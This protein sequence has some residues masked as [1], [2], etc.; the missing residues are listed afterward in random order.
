MNH[1]R[2]WL[3]VAL[4]L[5][6]C[7]LPAV[8][9]TP[10][11]ADLAGLEALLAPA[12]ACPAAT[13]PADALAAGDQALPLGAPQPEGGCN[14]FCCTSNLQCRNAC[15]DAAACVGSAGCKRCILL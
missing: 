12:L 3:A 7:S 10:A 14:T 9:E 11:P 8:A 6:V 5:A 4:V 13:A 1:R 15:G 2:L